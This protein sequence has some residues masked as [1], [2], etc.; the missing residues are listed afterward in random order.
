MNIFEINKGAYALNDF[1]R[2]FLKFLFNFYKD[3]DERFSYLNSFDFDKI[4]FK[5]APNLIIKDQGVFGCWNITFNNTIFLRP[6]VF[7]KRFAD[8]IANNYDKDS[9]VYKLFIG[10]EICIKS[11]KV[12]DVEKFSQLENLVGIFA[13]FSKDEDL[14]KSYNASSCTFQTI[15][16][17]LYHKYQFL[18]NPISY[19]FK[20]FIGLFMGYDNS[21]LEQEVRE[22]I[23]NKEVFKDLKDYMICFDTFSII[24]RFNETLNDEYIKRFKS[25]ED[26][27]LC[28][29][30]IEFCKEE[31]I[32]SSE[33]FNLLKS[34]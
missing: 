17:E 34:E 24:S 31:N 13:A 14:E 19:I 10:Y 27:E 28:K 12:L 6:S 16:H 21:F 15:L 8:Y 32:Y 25:L 5:Y 1:E 26:K 3:K 11:P 23:D 29:K 9:K 20:F 30:C 18:R 7:D 33:I 4:T 2:R 22:K